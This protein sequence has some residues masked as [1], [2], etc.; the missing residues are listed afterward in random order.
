MCDKNVNLFAR[1]SELETEIKDLKIYTDEVETD[2]EDL[3]ES[4]LRYK[5]EASILKSDWEKSKEE[6]NK[7]KSDITELVKGIKKYIHS[8]DSVGVNCFGKSVSLGLESH[9]RDAEVILRGIR[10]Y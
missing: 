5:Q 2:Y 6:N 10:G 3:M 1:I 7:L 4:F 8:V 9:I